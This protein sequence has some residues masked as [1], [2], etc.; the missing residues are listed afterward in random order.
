MKYANDDIINGIKTTL[1]MI[2]RMDFNNINVSTVC[3]IFHIIFLNDDKCLK[4]D[5]IL[6]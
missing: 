5:S 2:E 4:D 6:T 1:L 3:L